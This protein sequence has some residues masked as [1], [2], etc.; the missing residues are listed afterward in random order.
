[1]VYGWR[2]FMQLFIKWHPFHAIG[3]D[4]MTTPPPNQPIRIPKS[5]VQ[6]C[7]IQNPTKVQLIEF[8]PSEIH[9][10]TPSEFAPS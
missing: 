10:K 9:S 2:K 6:P 3:P 5:K 7:G 4:G 1:M 8:T